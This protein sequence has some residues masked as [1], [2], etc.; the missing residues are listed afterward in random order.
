MPQIT[1]IDPTFTHGWNVELMQLYPRSASTGTQ[2]RMVSTEWGTASIEG[3]A[4]N[5]LIAAAI[6]CWTMEAED[7]GVEAVIINFMRDTGL[8]NAWD[9]VIILVT[10]PAEASMHL[11]VI[12]G[13][14]FS[15]PME[16]NLYT[17]MMEEQDASYGLSGKLASVC[18]FTIPVFE[19]E[20]DP[21]ASLRSL[22]NFSTHCVREDEAHI[23]VPG[24]TG[25]VGMAPYIHVGLVDQVYDVPL[26]DSP[27]VAMN[28]SETL[29]SFGL[30]HR[31][32]SYAIIKTGD[33]LMSGL[34]I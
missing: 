25:L 29:V 34:Y 4:D 17:S 20:K 23:I 18:A 8:H 19:L 15:L 2:I 21:F 14:K 6:I 28:L 9:M 32:R 30:S 10:S 24:C 1:V 7:E 31:K 12:P 16:F 3:C 33:Y 22:I 5:T 13:H 27:P 26:L 11:A